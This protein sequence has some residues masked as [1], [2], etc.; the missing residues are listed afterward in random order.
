M[1]LKTPDGE[2]KFD[3]PPDVYMLDHTDELAEE[4]EA[5]ADLPYACRAGSCSSCAAKVQQSE[6]NVGHVESQVERSR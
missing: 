5:L 1:T 3:C 6:L 2:I 4:N